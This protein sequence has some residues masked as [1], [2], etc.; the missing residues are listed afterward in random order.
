MYN[1]KLAVYKFF[2]SF[3]PFI[4]KVNFS[5]QHPSNFKL[6][7]LFFILSFLLISFYD[8]VYRWKF[9]NIFLFL[10]LLFMNISLFFR[11]LTYQLNIYKSFFL[12]NNFPENIFLR[13]KLFWTKKILNFDLKLLIE[14]SEHLN[15]YTG[16]QKWNA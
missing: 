12:L 7:P 8:W 15:T 16:R 3:I 10:Y 1:I 2:F 5:I 13:I 14:S 11:N 4:R 9:I 6:L